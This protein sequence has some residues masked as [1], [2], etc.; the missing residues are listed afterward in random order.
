MFLFE[1]S[2]KCMFLLI[3]NNV[4]QHMFS[5]MRCIAYDNPEKI[6]E[7][8]AFDLLSTLLYAFTLAECRKC[9]M[10]HKQMLHTKKHCHNFNEVNMCHIISRI[11]DSVSS[12]K[13]FC[14]SS[15]YIKSFATF[16][17]MGREWDTFFG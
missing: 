5:N 1:T 10:F 9:E 6:Q 3:K 7:A 17:N 4:R 12:C 11:S 15:C 2:R 8:L 16:K 13:F 14:A